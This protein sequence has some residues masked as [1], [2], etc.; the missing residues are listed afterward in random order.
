L[1]SLLDW[2]KGII[3]PHVTLG[4]PP[5]DS[6]L[7]QIFAVVLCDLMWLSRNQA[8]HKGIVPDALK[9]AANIKRVAME[10]YVAWSSKQKPQKLN[11]SKPPPKCYKVNFDVVSCEDFSTQS[12][13]CRNSNGV[14]IK[15]VS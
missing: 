15:M 14:I 11:W 5:A 13:V 9:L 1:P 8:V 12:T 10:H 2:I 4:I 3:T 7:F 6:H